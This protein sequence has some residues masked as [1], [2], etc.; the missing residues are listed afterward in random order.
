M[1]RFILVL[2]LALLSFSDVIAQ[3]SVTVVNDT[4]YYKNKAEF[5]INHKAK[6]KNP[7]YFLFSMDGKH[8]VGLYIVDRDSQIQCSA[9]FTQLKVRYSVLYP[10]IDVKVLLE[11]F[12]RNKVLVNGVVDSAGL[13][14]YC[15]ER[16]IEIIS[17][18]V[19]KTARPQIND[20]L[21][22]ARAKADLENQVT[23]EI[24]NNADHD[25]KV[26]IGN[27]VSNRVEVVKHNSK[28]EYKA[29]KGEQ[30]CLLDDKSAS[31]SCVDVKEGMKKITVNKDETVKVE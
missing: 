3:D 15:K 14:N 30:I 20:S 28:K 6:T 4:V 5:I 13:A 24:E 23:I 27:K 10:K 9:H 19:K 17:M 11:S 26:K 2:G 22:A 21:M 18:D 31:K 7:V 25:V 29:R 16:K 12:I 1:L 8:Q